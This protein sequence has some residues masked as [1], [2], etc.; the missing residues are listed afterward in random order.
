MT[1]RISVTPGAQLRLVPNRWQSKFASEAA[2]I[3][4][5]EGRS[6]EVLQSISGLTLADLT[7]ESLGLQDTGKLKKN[8]QRKNI[9]T[10]HPTEQVP[11]KMADVDL[12]K[13]P[14]Q[15]SALISSGSAVEVEKIMHDGAEVQ[16]NLF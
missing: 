6:S 8:R 15:S 3:L 11:E 13:Q 5:R 1:K 2:E 16:E 12:V 10:M 7:G 14:T 9:H 4:I